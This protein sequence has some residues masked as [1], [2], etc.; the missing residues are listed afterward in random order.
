MATDLADELERFIER[1]ALWDPG[2]LDRCI[3]T[4][5]ATGTELARALLP[6]FAALQLRL[7]LGAVPVFTRL[8]VAG[9]VY[10]R[11]WKVL[12]ALRDDLPTGEQLTRAEVL[13]RR[14]ARVFAIED[15]TAGEGPA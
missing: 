8:D 9:V 14:L 6:T 4:L 2:E 10:P 3:A 5:G 15:V 1:G 11:L 13:S 12:E 7:E